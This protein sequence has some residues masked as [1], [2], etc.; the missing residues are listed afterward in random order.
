MERQADDLS[1][2]GSHSSMKHSS[3]SSHP[4]NPLDG[5]Q[6]CKVF[7][8]VWQQ[9]DDTMSAMSTPP[10]SITA[11][12]LTGIHSRGAAIP[13]MNTRGIQNLPWGQ[14]TPPQ[15]QNQQLA[16][17]HQQQHQQQQQNVRPPV[18]GCTQF[19]FFGQV[20]FAPVPPSQQVVIFRH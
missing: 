16:F 11:L 20:Q 9:E 6:H 10:N 3:A 1:S 8:P 2:Q 15:P 12:P 4:S 7:L 18:Q 5:Q 14:Q 19:G 17:W 13:L